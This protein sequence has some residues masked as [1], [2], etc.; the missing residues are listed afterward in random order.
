MSFTISK[1]FHFSASHRLDGLEAGHPCGRLHGHNY[2]VQLELSSADD[3]LDKNGFVRD[4]GDLSSFRNWLDEEVDHRHLNDLVTDQNPSAE[5]LAR[6][7]YERWSPQFPELSSVRLSE[8][9]K[10]SAE[11]RP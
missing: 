10:T 7:I 3:G 5:N 1:E 8:T 2:V 9:P 11:Y 4:Y 6:W